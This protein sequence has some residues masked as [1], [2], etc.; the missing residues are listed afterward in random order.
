MQRIF[1]GAAGLS[2]LHAPLLLCT[3]PLSTSNLI[4]VSSFLTLDLPLVSMIVSLPLSLFTVPMG[5][6][7]AL[8]L[9]LKVA[10]Y[11]PLWMWCVPH[12]PSAIL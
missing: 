3:Y 12:V 11:S 9:S 6:M 4:V 1:G 2:S 5:H 8:F 10:Q 7:P